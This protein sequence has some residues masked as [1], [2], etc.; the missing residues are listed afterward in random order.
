MS[1]RERP[2]PLTFITTSDHDDRV[3][4]LHSYKFAAALQQ[5]QASEKPI[6]LRVYRDTGHR[7]GRSTCQMIREVSDIMI[8][9][10]NL[11]N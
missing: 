1:G 10:A 2:I 4:P 6:L 8:F 3:V 9:L 5:A 7:D 11:L